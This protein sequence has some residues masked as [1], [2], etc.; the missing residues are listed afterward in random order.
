MLNKKILNHKLKEFDQA[1]LDLRKR[2]NRIFELHEIERLPKVGS[3]HIHYQE[4]RKRQHSFS[5]FT[6]YVNHM[7]FKSICDLACGNGWFLNQLASEFNR[8]VGIEV[9]DF[10]LHQAEQI[11]GKYKNVDLY[12]GDIFELNLDEKFDII[13]I[14][15]GIQYFHPLEN[16]I[17]RMLDLLTPNGEIH[18]LDSPF[19]KNKADSEL[20]KARSKSYYTNRGS[21]SLSRFYHHHCLDDLQSFNYKL[22][23]NPR[24]IINRLK[25]SMKVQ[26]PFYWI[27]ILT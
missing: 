5:M 11:L 22:M 24:S 16:I 1:Y 19:Y 15:A 3:D 27:K 26:S 23:Y 17:K 13:T 25:K 2:E 12:L 10:E 21:E 7:N 8:V 18:I 6:E 20:A 4:W 9:N 14:N